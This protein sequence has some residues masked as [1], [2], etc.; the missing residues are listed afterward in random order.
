VIDVALLDLVGRRET[1]TG[2]QLRRLQLA[3]AGHG[4]TLLVLT[5]Q[6]A[7]P[8]HRALDYGASVRLLVR[9]RELLWEYL[10]TQR[11]LNGY[12]LHVEV[13]RAPGKSYVRPLDLTVGSV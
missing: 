13:A 9:R 6:S 10:G 7:R 11:L 2:G 1:F 4:A 3:A 12:K 5:T 8:L